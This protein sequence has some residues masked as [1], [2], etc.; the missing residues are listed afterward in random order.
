[1]SN[2]ARD[3]IFSEIVSGGKTRVPRSVKTPHGQHPPNGQLPPRRCP[4]VMLQ[5]LTPRVIIKS[6]HEQART[7][8]GMPTLPSANKPSFRE[9]RILRGYH[10]ASSALA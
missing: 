8:Y 4:F 6:T 10:S 1:M 9:L 2:A 5:S 7:S 3:F